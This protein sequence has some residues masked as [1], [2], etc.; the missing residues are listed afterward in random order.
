MSSKEEYLL[1][2]RNRK[3][4]AYSNKISLKAKIKAAYIGA[5]ILWIIV[6][7]LFVSGWTIV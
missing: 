5:I 7:A 2:V 6:L 4:A 1:R 3:A